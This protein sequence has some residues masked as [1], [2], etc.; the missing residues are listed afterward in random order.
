[1]L[2]TSPTGMPVVDAQ[3][4]FLRARRAHAAARL[5]HIA[6][7]SRAIGPRDIDAWVS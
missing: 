1:M 4:D 2:T 6:Y 3:Q 7:R 5:V